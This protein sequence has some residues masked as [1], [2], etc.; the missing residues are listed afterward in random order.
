MKDPLE[1]TER[2]RLRRKKDRGHYDL[3]TITGILDAMP[4]CHIGYQQ[5]GAP[6]VMPNI[7]WHDGARVYWHASSG[8]HGVKS[9]REGPVCLTVSLLDGL[10]LARTGLNHSCN[11]RSVMIFGQPLEITDPDEK[12]AKLNHL[13][14]T[15]YPGRS[16]E[17]RPMSDSDIK[18]TAVFALPIEEASAKVR[19]TGVADE[20]ADY[21]QPVWC[22]VIPVETR[23]LSPQADDRN[24]D[25]VEMPAYLNSM[26]IG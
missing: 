20:E 13:I 15:L 17:L 11:F 12:A 9:W 16:G 22:G 4:M 26:N 8:G 5:Q 1:I 24:L 10:V 21:Q 2:T 14:D 7:Q 6:V 25:G 3:A 18:Q 19:Q 23:L